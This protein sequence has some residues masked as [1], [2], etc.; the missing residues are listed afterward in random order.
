MSQRSRANSAGGS[1]RG[2]RGGSSVKAATIIKDQLA[3]VSADFKT[4]F[5]SL[6]KV[7]LCLKLYINY[8]YTYDS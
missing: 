2:I 1:I 6:T 3:S 5:A 4:S 7:I 8:S